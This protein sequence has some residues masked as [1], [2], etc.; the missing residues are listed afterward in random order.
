MARGTSRMEGTRAAVSDDDSVIS[1]ATLSISL[2]PVRLESPGVVAA[3]DGARESVA[4]PAQ[5]GR[6]HVLERIGA[7][8]MGEVFAARDPELDR[9]I[10]IKLVH[11]D[12]GSSSSAAAARLLREAQTLARLNHPNVVQIFE[13]GTVKGRVYIAM[14][15][16]R[17]DTLRRFAEQ[18]PSIARRLDALQQCAA[19]LHAI[20]R[21]GL[22]HRD[23]KPDNVVVAADGRVRVVDFGLARGAAADTAEPEHVE[24]EPTPPSPGP[25]TPLSA[26]LTVT[27]AVVG[28]PVYMAPEQLRRQVI[29][30]R[31]DQF[32][33]CVMA[34]ELL[35]GERPFASASIGELF[36]AHRSGPQP[37][38]RSE[39]PASVWRVLTRGLAYESSARWPDMAALLEAMQRAVRPRTSRRAAIATAAGVLAVVAVPVFGARAESAPCVELGPRG[40]AAKAR[41]DRVAALR[42]HDEPALEVLGARIDAISTRR[43]QA[44]EGQDTPPHHRCLERA[45]SRVDALIDALAR[46]DDDI[47]D[48]ARAI[49]SLPDGSECAEHSESPAPSVAA[50]AEQA[51]V[52]SELDRASAELA[53][54]HAGRLRGRGAELRAMALATGS[55]G[56]QAEALAFDG[57][58]AG[59]LGES[60]LARAN[61]REAALQAEAERDDALAASAWLSVAKVSIGQLRDPVRGRDDLRSARAA[62]VRLG[63]DGLQERLRLLGAQLSLLEGDVA[64]AREQ[65]EGLVDALDDDDLAPT[66]WPL[67]D[68]AAD[69]AEAAGELDEAASLHARQRRIA[70]AQLGPEHPMLA[71]IDYN[72]GKVELLRGQVDASRVALD[73]ALHGWRAA[74]GDQHPDLALVHTALQQWEMHHGSLAAAREHAVRVLEIGRAQ[75]PEDHP[76]LALAW[77][78]IGAVALLQGAHDE[79]VDAYARALAIAERAHAPDHVELAIVRFDYAEAL[80]ERSPADADLAL[81]Q[82]EP[83]RAAIE[84]APGHDP[85]LLAFADRLRK[86]AL[87]HRDSNPDAPDAPDTRDA[88]AIRDGIDPKRPLPK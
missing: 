81:T 42:D 13:V 27:G 59:A 65:L 58:L 17:G 31:C 62:V 10:A 50:R 72:L 78:G 85:S 24:P 77:V 79:A 60:E 44:C 34:W 11:A 75:L 14:E 35:A 61:L 45:L 30:P 3:R 84:A 9:T 71:A 20:H 70:L 52:R 83:A 76:D 19:G 74:L 29:D 2:A 23:V 4:P 21:V 32:A 43:Q 25:H 64:S 46:G 53:L 12:L 33:F 47:L 5:I 48:R 49:A 1:R 37:P 22:V 28:T 73:R 88:P 16:V 36:E 55:T 26:R 41:L 15:I 51:R 38:A 40:D 63:D 54:G 80:L 67:L 56:L 66:R 7:G 68:V 6:Y 18:G 69:A 86:T 82:I 57:E 8:G 87:G 39:V